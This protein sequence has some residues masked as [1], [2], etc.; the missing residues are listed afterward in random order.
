[1]EIHPMRIPAISDTKFEIRALAVWG[2]AR[3][4]LIMEAPHN[5]TFLRVSEVKYFC[6][7]KTWMPERGSNPR[8]PTFQA[9]SWSTAADIEKRMNKCREVYVE[10][11]W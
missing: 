8:S 9:C 3:Y 7:F 4:P 6:F 10:I 2:R 11:A 5:I 1:M